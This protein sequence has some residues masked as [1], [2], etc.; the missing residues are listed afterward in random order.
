MK[1]PFNLFKKK[2][3][4][5]EASPFQ[6]ECRYGGRSSQLLENS[7]S[8]SEYQTL[9]EDN[10]YSLHDKLVHAV[11]PLLKYRY[12]TLSSSTNRLPS[13]SGCVIAISTVVAAYVLTCNYLH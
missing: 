7:Q 9:C 12:L 5:M 6:R 1:D 13:R 3:P 4:G 2:R 11:F 8:P 10:E